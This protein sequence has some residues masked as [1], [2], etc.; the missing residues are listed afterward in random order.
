MPN[1]PGI[2]LV[3]LLIGPKG[4]FQRLL[5]KQSGCKIYVNGK[6]I[7]KREKYISPNDNDEANVLIIGDTEEKLKRG[8][9]L[10]K[11]I[12]NA[13]DDTKNK[14][15]SEQFTV[16]KKEGFDSLNYRTQKNDV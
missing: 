5:E 13:D 4:I 1:T 10:V 8:V 16:L 9:N 12:I 15:I 14:I 11:E 2:N 6:N 3:G 7:T